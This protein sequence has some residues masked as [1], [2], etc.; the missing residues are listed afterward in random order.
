MSKTNLSQ[1]SD[2][3][4]S[5]AAETKKPNRKE[6]T[7]SGSTEA[8]AIE[9]KAMPSPLNCLGGAGIAGSLSVAIGALTWNIAQTFAAKPIIG[10]SA[11]AVNIGSAVRTLVV[12]AAALG[13][14]IFGFVALGL[15]ALAI[16]LTFWGNP[17]QPTD[18]Q[19]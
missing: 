3:A 9:P 17:S 15:I 6:K 4:S 19:R 8:K 14:G 2:R 13:T 5:G 18:G 12:G 16:Q 7:K 1:D 10:H 11:M